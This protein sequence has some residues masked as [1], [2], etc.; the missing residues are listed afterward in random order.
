MALFRQNYSL[1]TQQE[2]IPGRLDRLSTKLQITNAVNAQ[3]LY[4][5]VE[6]DLLVWSNNKATL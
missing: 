5:Y 2:N 6:L 1:V 4:N 3:M